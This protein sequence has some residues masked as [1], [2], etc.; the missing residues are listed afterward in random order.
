MN[1][2]PPTESV[3]SCTT[4]NI[5]RQ[6]IL[7]CLPAILVLT[8]FFGVNVL[9]NVLFASLAS[10]AAEALV[11][12]LRRRSLRVLQDGSAL[13]TGVLLGVCLPATAPWWIAFLGGFFAI[14][15]VK[16]L[17]GGLGHN[18]FNPA[19]AAYAFL[20]ISFPL[21]MSVW[22]LPL[23][24]ELDGLTGATAL[25]AWRNKGLLMADEFW[26]AGYLRSEVLSAWA[27]VALAWCVGGLYLVK[28]RLIYWPVPVAFFAT[29][30]I[31]SGLLWLGDPSHYAPPWLHFVAGSAVFA[32]FFIL[33]DPV[34]G[35]TSLQGKLYFALGVGVL[36]ISIRTWGSYPDGVAFSVLLMNVAAPALDYFTRPRAYGAHPP[37]EPPV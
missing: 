18:P 12:L 23:T 32:G 21:P 34:S 17:F 19:M 29:L 37:A 1:W 2:M 16:Q 6:V 30:F 27:W 7:A 4:A 25:D 14:A 8:Y 9:L 22:P 15:C 26:D 24:L 5:M 11:L 36:V 31:L 33:T 35:A 28:Q 3:A 13:L 20:L 10:L